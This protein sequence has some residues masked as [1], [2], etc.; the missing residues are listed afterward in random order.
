MRTRL[1]LTSA[2]AGAVLLTGGLTTAAQAA[3]APIG[4]NTTTAAPI[5]AATSV[6]NVETTVSSGGYVRQDIYGASAPVVYS[7]WGEIL[8]V[9]G[10]ARN[11]Y[12]NKWYAV[13][14]PE[15]SYGWIY[16]GNVTAGC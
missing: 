13:R 4:T 12:G 3:S 6:A 8:V 9:L 11:S 1:A 15:A 2:V 10:S 14:T 5:T 16:C 7:P